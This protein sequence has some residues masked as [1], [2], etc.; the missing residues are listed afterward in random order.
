MSSFS[1]PSR[2]DREDAVL[3]LLAYAATDE[4]LADMT[5]DEIRILLWWFVPDELNHLAGQ[6]LLELLERCFQNFPGRESLACCQ[7]SFGGFRQ[8]LTV[9]QYVLGVTRRLIIQAVKAWSD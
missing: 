6:P 1:S 8:S 3:R 4:G 5:F 2:E 9:T 7:R